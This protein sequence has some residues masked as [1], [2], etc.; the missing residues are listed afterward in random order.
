MAHQHGGA[1][2]EEPWRRLGGAH[3]AKVT[4]TLARSRARKGAARARASTGAA[5]VAKTSRDPAS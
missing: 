1:V 5:D 3:L 4:R 2:E